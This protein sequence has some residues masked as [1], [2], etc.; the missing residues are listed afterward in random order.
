[1]S[2]DSICDF[3]LSITTSN[4]VWWNKNVKTTLQEESA[5]GFSHI[6]VDL[7]TESKN[8]LIDR[9]ILI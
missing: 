3:A 4:V 5:R 2:R 6:S 1:M 9:P 7:H 8:L